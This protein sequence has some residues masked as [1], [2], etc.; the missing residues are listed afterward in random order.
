MAFGQVAIPQQE[1]PE[2]R[3]GELVLMLDLA[4]QYIFE[5]EGHWS[6][7]PHQQLDLEF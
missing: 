6:R 4:P 1:V 2:A 3:H 5:E 7:R